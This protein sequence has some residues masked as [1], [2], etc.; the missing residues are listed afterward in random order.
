MRSG[1]GSARPAGE[2]S[3]A[4]LYVAEER[5]SNHRGCRATMKAR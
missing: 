2:N 1:G 5:T 4:P 3:T